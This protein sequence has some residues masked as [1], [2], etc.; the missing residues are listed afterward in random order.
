MRQNLKFLEISENVSYELNFDNQISLFRYDWHSDVDNEAFF[1]HLLLNSGYLASKEFEGKFKFTIPNRELLLEFTNIIPQGNQNCGIILE[2]LKKNRQLEIL[3]MIRKN[4]SSED[5]I[6]KFEHKFTTYKINCADSSMNFNFMSLAIIYSNKK[7]YENLKTHCSNESLNVLDKA[8][9]YKV[10]D[11]ASA[12]QRSFVDHSNNTKFHHYN[13]PGYF[14]NLLCYVCTNDWGEWFIKIAKRFFPFIVVSSTMHWLDEHLNKFT[15][16]EQHAKTK[17]FVKYSIIFMSFMPG[18]SMENNLPTKEYCQE[19]TDF[20][21]MNMSTPK[22]FT[23]LKHFEKYASLHDNSH[24]VVDE[25]CNN[26]EDKITEI[27]QPIFQNP[28]LIDEKIKFTLCQPKISQ[29]RKSSDHVFKEWHPQCLET[30]GLQK[31]S[32]NNAFKKEYPQ[33][34][35][36]NNEEIEQKES[37]HSQTDQSDEV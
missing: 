5:F 6:H 19:Y 34:E 9:G 18:V 29:Q 16:F 28:Y 13:V 14:Y 20:Q 22:E 10:L 8:N 11:Y 25:A 35:S 1:S 26:K 30:G 21:E 27:V 15:F 31:Q 4:D 33:E 36:S 17:N 2:N 37:V 7:T 32:L 12:L 3:D 24:I 23:R